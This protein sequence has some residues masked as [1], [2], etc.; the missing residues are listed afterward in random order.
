MRT[1]Y[2][3]PVTNPCSN[4][5]DRIHSAF[6][7]QGKQRIFSLS[8]IFTR[9]V[10]LLILV[11]QPFLSNAQ[12]NNEAEWNGNGYSLKKVVS[13]TSIQSG[14]NFSYTIL[15]TAPAGATTVNIQDQI[16]SNLVVVNVPA[17]AIVNGVTPVVATTGPIGSQVVTYTLTSLP[18]GSP[19]SGS[20]TIVVKF[21]EGTTCNGTAARNR[22]GILIGQE[23]HYTPF[24]STTATAVDPWVVS[25]TILSGPVVNP[26]GGNCGYLMNA[27]TTVTYRLSVM[28]ANGYWGSNIGQ[29]NMTSSQ[30][31]DVLPVGAV[32][33]SATPPAGVSLLGN[34]ITWVPNSG[35]LDAANAWAYYWVDITVT[36]PAGPFPNGSFVYNQVNLTGS[37]CQQ[38]ATHQSNQTCIEIANVTP[39]PSGYFQKYVNVTNRVPGCQ[40]FYTII[41]CNN[42]NVPLTAFNINDV[43]PSGISVEKVQLYGAGVSTPVSIT[44]NGGANTIVS[45]LTSNWYDSGTIGYPVNNLQFA[46]TRSLPVGSCLYMYIYFNILSNPPGTQI[47]N[48]ATFNGLQNNLTLPQTCTTFTVAAGTPDPC[49]LKD[50]CSP[51]TDYEPG[52]IIR[53]RLRIQNIGS[54][55]LTGATIQDILN[56]NFQYI[57]NETYYVSSSYSPPCGTGN[58]IPSGT[59]AW[60][61]VTTNHSGNNLSWNLPSIPSDCQAFYVG[62]CGYYGTYGLPYYYIEFDVAVDGSTLPGVTPN[63]YTI[64]G[65]NLTGTV[66][67]NT[68][69]VLVVAKFGQETEKQVSTDNGVTYASSGTV[70]PGSTA[71]YRL[72]YKNTSNVPVSTVNLIDLLALD[73]APVNDYLVLNRSI[74]RG[75]QFDITYGATPTTSLLP[76]AAPPTPVI[77]FAAGE[78]ICLPPFGIS[79]GCN[80]TTWALTPVTENIRFNYGTF[81]LGS[82]KSVLQD[83]NVNIPANATPQQ[84]VCNDFAA[85]VTANFLL[86][87]N[88]QSVT[89]TPIAA[90]PVCLT[91]NTA[92]SCC[93]SVTIEKY[94]NATA[95]GCCLKL[96]SLCEIKSL[97]ISLYNGTFSSATSSCGSIGAG[98]AGQ[99][100]WTFAPGNCQPLDFY[101]CV[102]PQQGN[103]VIANITIHFANGDSC[104]KV[105][106]LDCGGSTT[107]DCCDSITVT[108]SYGTNGVIGCCT[109]LESKCDVEKVEVTVSNGTISSATW[110]CGNIGTGYAGQSNYTFQ[111]SGCPVVLYTCFDAIQTGSVGI[112][113]TITLSDGTVC[114]KEYKLDCQATSHACCDSVKVENYSDPTSADCCVK[115]HSKCEIKAVKVTLINGTF[116]SASSGCGPLSS[117]YAG[118]SSWIFAPGNCSPVDLITCVK[119]LQSGIVTA[120]YTIHF[121]NGD[122]CHKVFD[123]D[124]TLSSLNCCDSVKVEKYSDPTSNS[125]CS[126][127]ESKC[128]IKSVDI[129]LQNGTFSSATSSCGSLA[130]GYAGQSTWTFAPGNCAPVDLITCVTPKQTGVVTA[131]Y[132]IHFANGDSCHKTI[133]FDCQVTQY[134]CC[135]SIRVTQSYGTTGV[136]GCCT[137]LESKC[138]VQKVEVNISNG[139]ISSAT[140]NCGNIPA[141]YAGQS[142]YTFVANG[143]PVVLYNCFDAIQT[144]SVGITYTI[145]LADGSVCKKEF[146]LDCTA[147]PQNCCDSVKV[148]KVA[149]RD[150][151]SGCCAKVTT[152]CKV[153]SVLVNVTN[154]TIG[155]AS[156]NCGNLPAGYAGQTSYTFVPNGCI[157]D[158]TTCIDPIQTGVVTVTYSITFENG[159]TCKKSVELDCAVSEDC[160]AHIDFKLK[161][162]WPFKSQTGIFSITNLNPSSPI[163]SVEIYPSPAGTFTPGSL[164]VDGIPST[165]TWNSTSIPATGTLNTPAVN[166]L[167]FSMTGNYK[168]LITICV[169]KCD[170]QRCCFVYKWN[171]NPFTDVSISL[172]QL[173]IKDKLVAVSVNPV[174]SSSVDHGVKYISFGLRDESEVK[175]GIAQFFAISASQHAGDE[176]PESLAPP[177]AAFMGKYNA[178]FELQQP[179]ASGK[180]LGAFNLVFSGKL[181]KLGCTLYDEEGNII[182]SGDINV[183]V[184]DSIITSSVQPSM[185]QT[186]MFEFINVYPNPSSYGQFTITYANSD[187]REIEVSVVNEKGQI[188]KR[189]NK[190][191][192]YPGIHKQTIDARNYPTGIYQMVITSGDQILSKSAVKK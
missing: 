145:T 162:K 151:T 34:T 172:E 148:E 42:G 130:S 117:G 18:A 121:A 141:G 161:Q 9:I 3:T 134:D 125:C 13:N 103:V 38:P 95:P 89:L 132:T 181:P 23:W 160:C 32:F 14:V 100:T 106:D 81:I 20:F 1:L 116:S 104:A 183:R 139:T 80:T 35:L 57:G 29:M 21:P 87:G 96:H 118:Q 137:K 107:P 7:L 182:Y 144:G 167:S 171:K 99:S 68:V 66:T 11:I 156:W 72:K 83:F 166:N 44:A 135:D 84:T 59:T 77:N 75:S 4:M 51:Q 178:F 92:T 2:K 5:N 33:G 184:N 31:T 86:N 180:D 119:P 138:D 64:S 174:V 149:N 30:V 73:A 54:A 159:E 189:F 186:N 46:M 48:C 108:Q 143:C 111:A 127:L 188:M 28:K 78:N 131:N 69:N 17:P 115:I 71:R 163:C 126:K 36:Y 79:T 177:V 16:P 109:K 70:A 187:K 43:I 15:F 24:V 190:K 147:V 60:N 123:F 61:G 10:F 140:W 50:I 67:S 136:I 176:Y 91:V 8:K 74:S 155:S 53:F 58:G 97:D 12:S 112:T 94:S 19:S 102:N 152:T 113:Y 192:E 22:A 101:A 6:D 37:I 52:D 157:V 41:F 133:D 85:I 168:G 88:P 191:Y 114:T 93:D 45:G 76:V 142:N 185:T 26:N 150:G 62:Y 164:I 98:Y 120:Y 170:G 124:C 173:D 175:E 40:G 27:G 105:L 55:N 146:K 82:G 63:N 47:T 90:A 169:V 154:G 65:G 153:K 110:N 128:E 122:T 39:N 165:Q 25:K 56:T 129:S 49:L 179:V 158:L